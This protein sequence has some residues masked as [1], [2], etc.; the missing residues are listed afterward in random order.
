MEPEKDSNQSKIMIIA[1][2]LYVWL[3]IAF[4]LGLLTLTVGPMRWF[5]D[6]AHRIS[7]P[8]DKEALYGKLIIVGY[9]VVTLAIA[10][11]IS[12][13]LLKLGK[14]KK[15]G[16]GI[17]TMLL[18]ISVGIFVFN[19]KLLIAKQADEHIEADNNNHLDKAQFTLGAYPDYNQLKILKT[20]GYTA[21]VSLLHPLVVPAEPKLLNEERQNAKDAGIDLIEIPMLPWISGNE[22]ATKK[23]RE[24]A[25]MAKGKYYVHCYLGKDRVNAFRS[26]IMDENA[27][28]QASKEFDAR[29]LKGI[30]I[31]ERGPIIDI[32]NQIYL[33]PYPTDEEFMGYIFNGDIKTIV[34]TLDPS[35]SS[36]KEL[37]A[38]EEKYAKQYGVTFVNL[39]IRGNSSSTI[40][41]F[42][43]SVG[44]FKKPMVI[45][46]YD[47]NDPTTAGI[48][49]ALTKMK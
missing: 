38:K 1:Q 20:E 42:A 8:A 35:K 30:K 23:I 3:C 45:H 5:A 6:Y 29:T 4:P 19:P 2:F 16:I 9:I 26:I 34:N 27:A 21:I 41:E 49:E 43:S 17:L 31:F 37:I 40:N 28:Y 24:L 39:P 33:T 48:K 32:G 22:E 10:I 47:S 46:G 14:K 11:L 13:A 12:R 44:R 18:I 36:Y 7:M 25:K 15:G